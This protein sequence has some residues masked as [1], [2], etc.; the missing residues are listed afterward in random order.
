[1]NKE[2]PM[3]PRTLISALA[4]SLAASSGACTAGSVSQ[5]GPVQ[6][7]TA[8]SDEAQL[9]AG[10]GT[11]MAWP[12]AAIT[13]NGLMGTW[14]IA[15]WSPAAI[16]A[17]AFD[18]AGVTTLGVTMAN[19]AM[20]ASTITTPF[21]NA[22]VPPVGAT[23]FLGTPAMLGAGG[24]FA[25]AFG[26]TGAFAPFTGLG[27]GIGAFGGGTALTGSWLNGAFT[28]GWAGAWTP[29]LTANALMFTN[30]AAVNLATPLMFNVT[31]MAQSAAQAAA[32]TTTAAATAATTAAFANTAALS[33]FATPIMASALATTATIPFMSMA[34]PIMMPI[35]V[36]APAAV[37]AP[38]VAAPVAA[39]GVAF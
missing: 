33:V 1:M 9:V 18:V 8:I 28:P 36:I 32:I 34:F 38:V 2:P 21:L 35:P 25:P 37:A 14:P 22:F 26:F 13:W 24:L 30:L 20:V 3:K 15:V 11:I 16:G 4:L 6:E 7:R 19:S 10:T 5:P 12:T 29:A 31:F 23:P 27:F 39:A 17:V